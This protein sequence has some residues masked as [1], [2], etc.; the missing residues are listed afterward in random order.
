M[1]RHLRKSFKKDN[2]TSREDLRRRI[3][4]HPLTLRIPRISASRLASRKMMERALEAPAPRQTTQALCARSTLTFVNKSRMLKGFP[5][6]ST[7]FFSKI[8]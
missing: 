5:K 4:P 2:V 6:K 8:P 3:C 7:L 1:T